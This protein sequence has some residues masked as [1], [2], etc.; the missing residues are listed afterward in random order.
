MTTVLRDEIR[1]AR[2]TYRCDAYAHWLE[3]GMRDEDCTTNEQRLIL[4]AA[5]AD[6]G[7]ILRGQKYRCVT[8]I[9]DGDLV[10]WRERVGM[11]SLCLAHDL[12]D[13]V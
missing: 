11:G 5:Q 1:S 9:Q 10:T 4:S 2:K 8:A 13:N 6:N 7:R 3:C 12:Y